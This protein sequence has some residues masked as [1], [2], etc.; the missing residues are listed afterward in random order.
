MVAR[1][2]VMD[3]A[4]ARRRALQPTASVWVAASAGTGKTTVLTGRV[5]SLMIAGAPPERLL[6]LTFTK[7][8]A[9]E[10]ANRIA[11]RLG[12]WATCAEQVLR[13]E[14]TELTGAAPDAERCRH[15][16]RLFARVLEAPG[17]MKIQTIHA[18]CQS[19]LRRFPLEAGLAP[20]FTVMDPLDAAEMLAA[21]QDAVLRRARHGE[22]AA[23]AAALA[24][25]TRHLQQD[26]FAELMATL[27]GERGRLHRL[28]DRAGGLAAVIGNIRAR[29][30]VEADDAAVLA[31]ACAE[32]AFDGAGLRLAA[33]AMLEGSK[34]DRDHG[35]GIADWLAAGP[36]ARAAGFAGYLKAFFTQ[37]GDGDRF[38]NLAHADAL[39]ACPQAEAALADEAARLAA[40]RDRL[41]AGA[42]A[43]A[44]AALLS[45]GEAMLDAYERRKSARALLDYD[46]LILAAR[47]LL[48]GGVHG[49]EGATAWV[50]YKLDGGIDHILIDEAQDTNPDQWAVVRALAEEFFAGEGAREDRRTLFVVGDVKQS[51]FSFQRAD[52]DDFVAMRGFF[53]DRIEAA[54]RRWEDVA[55]DLSYR[56]TRAVLDAVDAV[57]AG[58][59]AADG[60]VDPGT[61]LHHR[62]WRARDAGRVE[63]WPPVK[64]RPEDAE[65]PWKPPVERQPGDAPPARLARLIARR[66]RAWIDDGEILEA[67]DRPVR[68]G[69]IMVLVRR[70]G[71][72]VEELVRELKQLEVAVAGVD[73]MVLTEQLAVMDLAALGRFLLLP[74]DDLTL[75]TVLKGPLVGLDEEAL[76][77][78]AHGRDGTLWQALRRHADDEPGFAA[79]HAALSAWLAGAD[80]VP[81]YE[82]FADI[83]GGGGAPERPSGRHRL[84]GRL[85]FEADDPIDEFLALALAYQ[86][87]NPPSLEGFLHWLEAGAVEVKR[88]LEQSGR[89]QVRVMTVHG[90]KGLQAPIVILP[91]T[92]QVPQKAPA[93]IWLGDDAVLWPPRRGLTDSVSEAARAAALARR[94]REYRRLLYVAMTRAEDRL[95]VCGWETKR[96]APA[97]CWYNLVRDGLAEAATEV[98]DPWLAGELGDPSAAVLRLASAQAAPATAE[99]AVAET[100]A[101]SEPLPF[102]RTKPPVEPAP[103]RPLAPSRPALAEPSVRSPIGDDDGRRFRR[104]RLIHR[105]LQTLPA[106]PPEARRPAAERFLARPVHGLDHAERAA[107]A[108][109]ACA[110]LCE[111]AALFGPD[112]R[113]EVPVIGRVGETV[114]AGQIDRLVATA[115]EVLIVDYKTNRAPPVSPE[116]TPPAYL[117]QMAAYRAVLNGIYPEIPVRCALVWTD[118]PEL[119]W[120]PDGLLDGHAPDS[121]T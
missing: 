106:L 52:P 65:P 102:A 12:R 33:A 46:D 117:R 62:A 16:R 56:S 59:Q 35:R 64:P 109:A 26:A 41:R 89:D 97:G 73:R 100:P 77:R 76:F 22:D 101:A 28:I 1:L 92:L 94:D 104:G 99:T 44:S 91:D 84:V 115:H 7:A 9:A 68:A 14:I 110:V 48:T 82:L 86:R 121:T 74:E 29:L 23:L 37:A 10:V 114:V 66:I 21:A 111:F 19:L 72:F 17:G 79:A 27:A 57:F 70:R 15:A 60:V 63:I 30:G 98:A 4:A 39:A 32:K 2:H 96:T 67:R 69:D 87:H 47:A 58:A 8:A 78:L 51:I 53:K 75:A 116:A 50:L 25:V 113:A 107:L 71:G 34:T 6:C 103:P 55:L 120:L 88:D 95:Y 118:G 3:T 11:D 13:D 83:L 105:L 112:S 5:L 31:V 61:S 93:L 40:V 49:L 119:M 81:P 18:F 54:Q 80:L 85:G 24:E 20:H 108:E 38:K 43:R 36:A 45:L 42:V 90:A